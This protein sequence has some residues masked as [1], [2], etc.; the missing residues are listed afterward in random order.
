MTEAI[1]RPI[2]YI[3]FLI[4]LMTSCTPKPNL[5]GQ[6]DVGGHHLF[7]SCMGEIGNSPTIILEH[8][9]GARASSESW[10]KV[11]PQIAKFAR[12]CRYDRAN[13]GKSGPSDSIN[14]R[15]KDLAHDLQMLLQKAQISGPYILVGHSFGGLT[16]RTFAHAYPSQVKGMVL[17]DA[18]HEDMIQE[19]PLGPE[20]L[21]LTAIGQEVKQAGPFKDL[22]LIVVTRGR[23]TG[24]RWEAFQKRL[25]GL[26]TKAKQ[27]IADRSGHEI[28]MQ[29][30]DMVVQAVKD[31]LVLSST[32]R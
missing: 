23:G 7:L 31:I 17:V 14:R 28:P 32:S 6:Y 3:P 10:V 4:L 25:L 16:V 12:V 26:S 20:K 2:I 22:P 27:V 21:N 24:P 15:S 8:G 29:Q 18:A 13:V 30:P 1:P 5:E 19:I 9:I 11:Q